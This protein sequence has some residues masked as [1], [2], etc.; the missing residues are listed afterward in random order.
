MKPRTSP[1]QPELSRPVAVDKISA[2][3][4]DEK[5]VAD[6]DERALLAERFGLIELPK[7]EAQLTVRPTRGGRMF[8]VKGAMQADVVQR[9]VVTLEPLPAR[10]EQEIKVLYAAPEFLEAEGVH[11]VDMEAEDVEPIADGIID[12]GELLAQSLGIALD[13]YP[14]KPGVAYVEKEYGE[15][16]ETANPFAKLSLLTKK[17]KG[18]K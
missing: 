18:K 11:E 9:C 3:G 15:G 8:E 6:K 5:I 12:L 2:G 7:L 17:D 13:P 4:A 16:E 14:R 10:I 1:D